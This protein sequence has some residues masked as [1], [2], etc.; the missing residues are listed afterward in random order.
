MPQRLTVL[1]NPTV[2]VQRLDISGQP[3]IWQVIDKARISAERVIAEYDNEQAAAAHVQRIWD[4][5]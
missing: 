1:G 4:A 5:P 2:S 3:A